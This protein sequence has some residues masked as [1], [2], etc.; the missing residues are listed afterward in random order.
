MTPYSNLISACDF[1]TN[2]NR[3]FT[4]IAGIWEDQLPLLLFQ[5]YASY[6]TPAR[7][8]KEA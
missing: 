1:I 5:N 4:S 6:K 7:S 3:G 8:D 2:R